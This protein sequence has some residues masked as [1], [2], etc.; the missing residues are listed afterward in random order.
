[1]KQK[2][3]Y[4]AGPVTGRP[5]KEAAAQFSAAEKRIR[6][7][8]AAG[9]KTE[10]FTINPMDFCS[11]DDSW[12]QAMR[13]C[14]GEMVRCGGIALLQGWQRSRGATLELKLAQDIHIPVVYVEPPLDFIGLSELFTAAQETLRYYNARLSQF[15]RE[16]V[17]E[18]LAEDRAIAE[19]ANRYLDP[20]GFEYIEISEGE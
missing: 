20:H 9:S 2:S 11:P 8:A 17:E 19:L 7:A 4:I 1:M 16:G 18:L 10:I 14:V 13:I 12:Q 3:I 15:Q 6:A 5:W